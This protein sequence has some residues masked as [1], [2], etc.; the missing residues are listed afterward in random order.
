M[1]TGEN[2]FPSWP[3]GED[4]R[5]HEITALFDGD[6]LPLTAENL[7]SFPVDALPGSYAAMV[8][9]TAAAL[10]VDTAMVGPMVLGALSAACGGHVEAQVQPDWT[11]TAVLFLT[12]SAGPSERKSPTMARAT[13][14][15]YAAER[16]MVE[17][18]TEQRTEARTRR[19]IAEQRAKN[20]KAEASKLSH[21]PPTSA[22]TWSTQSSTR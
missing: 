4:Q 9:A 13:A 3:E 14:P 2:M 12:V 1:S 10:Q 6:P 8:E 19:E 21:Q 7:P 18:A 11:E 22:S 20:A 17:A 15:V 16:V 5:E